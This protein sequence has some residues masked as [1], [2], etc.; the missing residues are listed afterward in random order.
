M[1]LKPKRHHL[2]VGCHDIIEVM[3]VVT[4]CKCVEREPYDPIIVD[5]LINVDG[6]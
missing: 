6:S 3:L 5:S 1:K 4:K 2:F